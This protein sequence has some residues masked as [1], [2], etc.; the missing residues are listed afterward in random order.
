MFTLIE[1]L[2]EAG[3]RLGYTVSKHPAGTVLVK[4]F[5]EYVLLFPQEDGSVIYEIREP[6]YPASKKEQTSSELELRKVL[7]ELR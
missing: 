7:K 3:E 4:N 5:R 2:C 6:L 1:N